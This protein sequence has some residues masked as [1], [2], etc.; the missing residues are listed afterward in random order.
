M[1]HWNMIFSD[2]TGNFCTPAEPEKGE[3][4]ALRLRAAKG[5]FL[6]VS[7]CSG[8]ERTPMRRRQEKEGAFDFYEGVTPLF[9]NRS[10]ITMRFMKKKIIRKMRTANL[11]GISTAGA[12][13][14]SRSGL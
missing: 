2:E 13:R 8:Q 7:L 5:D 12:C 1:I 10:L 3:K 4:V 6:K 14:G 11:F 9:G